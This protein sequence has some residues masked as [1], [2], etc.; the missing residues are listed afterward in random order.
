MNQDP[1][2]V[3]VAV[4]EVDSSRELGRVGKVNASLEEIGS[5]EALAN[6]DQ[7]TA[8]FRRWRHDEQLMED[9]KAQVELQS[10]VKSM[11]KMLVTVVD[12]LRALIAFLD[13]EFSKELPA[14][15]E[16]EKTD[17]VGSALMLVELFRK[18]DARTR[19]L[20]K[21]L[22]QAITLVRDA[23]AEVK[24]IAK[25]VTELED[26][27]QVSRLKMREFESSCVRFITLNTPKDHKARAHLKTKRSRRGTANGD[28]A[29]KGGGKNQEG[30]SSAE[31]SKQQSGDS[32]ATPK[33]QPAL[34]LVGGSSDGTKH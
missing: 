1:K 29:S 2:Q 9:A 6:R 28:K 3:N 30:Q 19:T 24:V 33:D 13:P 23:Q 15:S 20:G 18:H 11:L 32:P 31:A 34:I 12:G 16:M 25:S 4:V 7:L 10:R 17:P 8:L 21:E 26:Q 27:A 14:K 5:R 22:D